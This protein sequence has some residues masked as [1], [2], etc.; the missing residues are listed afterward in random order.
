MK[1]R[2]LLLLICLGLIVTSASAETYRFSEDGSTIAFGVGHLLGTARGAFRNF[3]GTISVDPRRPE[4]STVD[5]TI[6]VASIDT[7]IERRDAHLRSAEFLDVER[8]P[9][10]RFRS[11]KVIRTGPQAGDI[12]GD[13]TMKGVTRPLTLHVQLVMP[14]ARDAAPAQ[15]QWRVTTEP[16]HRKDFG[17]TFSTVAERISGIGSEVIPQIKIVAR[18]A[19]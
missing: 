7:S 3:R 1:C 13:F 15:T 2:S 11:R 12:I 8:F 14:L 10:I 16:I 5:V 19:E 6:Q 17:V 4:A 9:T 18:L